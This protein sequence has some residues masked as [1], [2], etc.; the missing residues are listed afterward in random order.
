MLLCL[1]TI[2][3]SVTNCYPLQLAMCMLFFTLKKNQN[4]IT[5]PH[6]SSFRV[7][8]LCK[9][10]RISEDNGLKFKSIRCTF[11]KP[12]TDFRN[13]NKSLKKKKPIHKYSQ[14]LSPRK[15][16]KMNKK[17]DLILTEFSMLDMRATNKNHS[18]CVI[19]FKL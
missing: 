2:P 18:C 17:N 14:A 10:D 1:L 11:F 8:E 9:R 6:L 3:L 15:K 12:D 19:T 4:Y 7:G 13:G 16:K 5:M